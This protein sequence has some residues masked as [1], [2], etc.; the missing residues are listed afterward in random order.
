MGAWSGAG[1]SRDIM[2]KQMDTVRAK[3]NAA[4]MGELAAED[5]YVLALKGRNKM[6]IEEAQKELDRAKMAWEKELAK[7]WQTERIARK[8]HADR[9]GRV[10][11]A[12]AVFGGLLGYSAAQFVQ[13]RKQ[14]K[15]QR[16]FRGIVVSPQ[17]YDSTEIEDAIRSFQRARG[18]KS[19]LEATRYL[20]TLINESP[21]TYISRAREQRKSFFVDNDGNLIFD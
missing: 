11:T 18:I 4:L 8:A 13:R 19:R 10:T 1:I 16:K 14:R 5:K 21:N 7:V 17:M 2:S 20:Q 9:L 3:E 6:E 12:G 15:Y